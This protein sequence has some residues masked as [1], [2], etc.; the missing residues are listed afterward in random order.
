MSKQRARVGVFSAAAIV[1]AG[2]LGGPLKRAQGQEISV[3]AVTNVREVF[4]G[5][6]FPFK[7][8]VRGSDAP[9]TPDLSVL[10]DFGVEPFR[11]RPNRSESITIIS[12]R[13]TRVVVFSYRL[14]PRR[15]G[16]LRIPSIPVTVGGRVFGTR[17]RFITAVMPTETPE[18]RERFEDVLAKV[19]AVESSGIPRGLEIGLGN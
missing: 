19:Q 17:A 8:Q 4:V 5:Q 12:G 11:G 2:L 10:K 13:M 6:S 1:L 3:D 14:T 18:Q 9:Q 15:A 7:I 16:K